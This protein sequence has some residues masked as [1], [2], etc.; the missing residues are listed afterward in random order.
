MKKLVSFALILALLVA[1]C[2]GAFAAL[3]ETYVPIPPNQWWT[4][5]GTTP[6][7]KTP[8][9]PGI[10]T[11]IGEYEDAVKIYCLGV[12]YTVTESVKEKD[13]VTE[14]LTPNEEAPNP[15]RDIR[16]LNRCVLET[17]HHGKATL[18]EDGTITLVCPV[19]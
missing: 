11:Y 3:D 10:W 8:S 5:T 1:T 12:I 4:P 6:D 19:Y 18:N 2:A 13:C 17:G 14:T 9:A 7:S 16:V 15:E